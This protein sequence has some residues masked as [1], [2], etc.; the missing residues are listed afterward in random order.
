MQNYIKSQSGAAALLAAMIV[1]TGVLSVALSATIIALNDR[2]GLASFADSVQNFYSAEAGVGESLMQIRKDPNDL[3]FEDIMVAGIPVSSDFVE[4]GGGACDQPPE[5][6]FVPDSGWWGEYFNYSVS[7]PDMEV[8]PYPGPTPTP[9]EHDWYDDVYK[10]HTQIDADLIFSTSGW[11]P[12]DGTAWEDM[13]GYNHDYHFGQHW[14]ARV[15]TPAD[16]DYGYSLASDDDSWVLIDGLV[17]VNNSGTHAANVKT[18]DV[19]LSAGENL[20][21]VYFAE[22]HTVESGFSFGFDDESLVITPYPEGC[23]EDL[24][25]NSNIEATASTTRATR[26]VRYTCNNNI[27]N[28]FWTELTP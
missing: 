21:E 4:E 11:F 23:Q 15:I 27:A 17:V 12:Y 20:V 22:R 7:H 10:T 3:V 13:E 18:G 5:C 1:A 26:K 8:N 2:A 6:R 24:E 14:R 16:D 19:F 28:C 9:T 25:C